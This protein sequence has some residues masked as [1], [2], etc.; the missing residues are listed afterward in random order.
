MKLLVVQL[1]PFSCYVYPKNENE[2]QVISNDYLDS[3]QY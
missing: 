3:Y 1:P 2:L